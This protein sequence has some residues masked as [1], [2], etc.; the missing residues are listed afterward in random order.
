MDPWSEPCAYTGTDRCQPA[1]AAW[2]F[3]ATLLAWLQAAALAPLLVLALLAVGI[4]VV[5]VSFVSWIISSIW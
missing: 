1:T 2:R 3:L 5:L 4:P